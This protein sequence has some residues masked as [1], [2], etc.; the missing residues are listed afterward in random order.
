MLTNEIEVETAA[1]GSSEIDLKDPT[2]YLN[3]ELT[4]LEFNRRVLHEAQDSRTPLL[5][6]VIG[7]TN[8][9]VQL[10][11]VDVDEADDVRSADH[12]Q[13]EERSHP[14]DVDQALVLLGRGELQH[15]RALADLV[16]RI[17]VGSGA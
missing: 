6:R 14:V 13:V 7:E 3:R 9:Q 16:Q 12:R 8:G 1:P 17:H 15:A 10:V 11:K 5:E 2:L 4:W